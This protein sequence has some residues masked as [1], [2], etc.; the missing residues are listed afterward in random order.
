MRY[1]HSFLDSKR[2]AVEKLEKPDRFGDNLV[3]MHQEAAKKSGNCHK[4][5]PNWQNTLELKMEE[6]VSG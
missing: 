6:W 4:T 2:A 5:V 3:T 1:A